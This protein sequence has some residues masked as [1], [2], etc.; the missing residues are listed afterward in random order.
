MIDVRAGARIRQDFSATSDGAFRIGAYQAPER[1]SFCGPD[2]A[3][4]AAYGWQRSGDALS[5]ETR[6]DECAD[7]DSILSGE[8]RLR[9]A[10]RSKPP[11]AARPGAG[12]SRGG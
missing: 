10:G 11:V 1:G 9:R 12:S 8:W 7:R 6:Q 4:T 2:I 5:L 3:Q